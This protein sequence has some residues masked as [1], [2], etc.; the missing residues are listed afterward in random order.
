MKAGK[1]IYIGES[2]RSLYERNKEHMTDREGL[3]EESHQVKHWLT[4]H[5]DLQ[6]PPRFRFKLVRKFNDPMSRQLAEAVRIELRGASILNSKSE[7]TRCRVPRLRIDLEGWKEKMV[8]EPSIQKDTYQEEETE[9][10]LEESF[11]RKRK[12]VDEEPLRKEPKRMR[13]EK[14]EG[15]GHHTS[16]EDYIE[17]EN[18]PEGWWTNKVYNDISGT[19]DMASTV[20]IKIQTTLPEGW[21]QNHEIQPEHTND[22]EECDTVD[23]VSSDVTNIISDESDK[24]L[25][26]KGGKRKTSPGDFQLK[27]KGKLNQKEIQELRKTHT[28]M[29]A[30]VVVGKQKSLPMPTYKDMEWEDRNK[31]EKLEMLKR[32]QLQW[33][34]QKLCRSLLMEMVNDSV[35]KV[36]NRHVFGMVT[37]MV[38]E[39]WMRFEGNRLL[40]VIRNSDEKIQ[41]RVLTILMEK[42][43]KEKELLDTLEKA[44]LTRR[45]M[46]RIEILK[47]TWMKRMEAKKLRAMLQM[48]GQLSLEELEMDIAEIQIRAKEIMEV[49]ESHNMEEQMELEDSS[50]VEDDGDNVDV[51]EQLVGVMGL[52]SEAEGG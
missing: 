8:K 2:S 34:S 26:L 9:K 31:E 1:R 48:L 37:S 6:A 29:L 46:N 45:R 49:V 7:Y 30:W 14:L 39:A 19:G 44:E 51:M 3:K 36:E 40:E 25:V 17:D 43:K 50:T 10:S 41:L 23:N 15:W 32:K 13:L 21:K 47:N 27:K 16:Q 5:Q 42:K 20:K 38:D 4:D 33:V 18:I 12:L 22:T 35:E 28:S 24:L 11:D 52:E